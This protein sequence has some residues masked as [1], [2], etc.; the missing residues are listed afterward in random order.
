MNLKQIYEIFYPGR[1]SNTV[2]VWNKKPPYRSKKDF[3]EE[4]IPME[5]RWLNIKLWNDKARRSRFWADSK[6]E[7]K[8]TTEM[9]KFILQ[10]PSSIPQTAFTGTYF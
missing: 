9:K 7:N 1:N 6:T 5:I 4:L 10:S 2:S 3:F 8:Y